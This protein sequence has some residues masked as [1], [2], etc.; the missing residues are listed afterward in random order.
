MTAPIGEIG[1]S[2]GSVP[3]ETIYAPRIHYERLIFE[4]LRALWKRKVLVATVLVVAITGLIAA[5]LFIAPRYT[6]EAMIQLDFT[7]EGSDRVQAT[8]AVDAAAIVDGVARIIRSRATASAVVSVLGLDDDPAYT[9]LSST[10]HALLPVWMAFGLPPPTAR[11][12]AVRRLMRQIAVNNDPRSYLITV[13]VTAS[14]PERAARLANWVVS[15]YLRARLREQ[16]TEAYAA[17]EREMAALSLVYGP[18]H[19]NYVN[20]SA[21]LQRVKAQLAA[22]REGFVTQ[23][24]EAVLAPDMVRS[25]A[26]QSLI[27][28]EVV[29]L[30]SG[31]NIIVLFA[32]TTLAALIV[33]ALL[34]SLAERGL[35]PWPAQRVAVRPA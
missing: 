6:G 33:G 18:R 29:L 20:G 25:A 22:V 16:A 23:E 5:L 31:P 17:A 13:D 21:K 35:F 34:S 9:Q 32:L 14:D 1:I 26:G 15:E 3:L 19:P 8:A 24:R 30:P 7:R 12:L 10:E 27:P 28:A 2:S 4:A 11:D